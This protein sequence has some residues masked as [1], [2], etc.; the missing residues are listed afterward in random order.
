MAVNC[1]AIPEALLESELFGHVK[2]AFTDAIADKRGLFEE[3]Q[4]GTLL[5]DEIGELPVPLQVKLLRVLQEEEI[6]R[7]GD[8]RSR[9]VDVRVIAATSRAL[10]QMVGDGSFRQDLY[11]RLNVMPIE[12]PPL[13]ERREDVV[14]LCAHVLAT[15]NQRLGTFVRTFDE[16]AIR[17]LVAYD[18]PGNVRELENTIEH[19][20]VLCEG[21]QLRVQDLPERVRN[22]KAPRGGDA[23]RD[24]DL[25]LKR[26]TRE[27]EREFILRALARTD[28]NRTHAARLLQ[29]SHRGLLYKLKALGIE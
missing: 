4:G 9:A 3:A 20:A 29:L 25:S 5:L 16:A 14:P 27:L 10:E 13:R 22:A 8:T 18:W 12:V 28:G 1:A 6:R 7:V 19:A 21:D 26:A 24:G 23:D 15:V 17:L 11:Y 2:G